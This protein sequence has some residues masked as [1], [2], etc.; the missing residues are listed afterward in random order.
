V[1]HSGAWLCRVFIGISVLCGVWPRGTIAVKG[2]PDKCFE[3]SVVDSSFWDE[4]ER[5]RKLTGPQRMSASL[6]L[7][8]EAS[9]RMLAGIKHQFP[10]LSDEEARHIRRDRLDRMRQL[11]AIQ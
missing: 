7:F 1:N 10:E 8:D 6:T 9:R 3:E 4:I 5:S 11:E 2:V